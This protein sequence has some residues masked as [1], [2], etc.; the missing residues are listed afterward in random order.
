METDED[1]LFLIDKIIKYKGRGKNKE[2]LVSWKGWPK[3][4]NSWIPAS[5]LIKLKQ[6]K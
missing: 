4:F 2:V 5:N 1:S 6:E 3:K